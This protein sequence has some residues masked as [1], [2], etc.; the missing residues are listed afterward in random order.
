MDDN[1]IKELHC[2]I[3]V[4]QNCL[5]IAL[6]IFEALFQS[7]PDQLWVCSAPPQVCPWVFPTVL[8][9]MWHTPLAA[10]CDHF[11]LQLT[12]TS[13]E[14]FEHPCVVWQ[15]LQAARESLKSQA[16]PPE[17]WKLLKSLVCNLSQH[18]CLN[19]TRMGFPQVLVIPQ[20]SNP[21]ESIRALF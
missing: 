20:T 15:P 8:Q 7:A 3:L 4:F 18:I 2:H 6:G 10:S 11:A 16:A 1:Y 14:S 12:A 19:P 17:L 9:A 21:T 5:F 13:T